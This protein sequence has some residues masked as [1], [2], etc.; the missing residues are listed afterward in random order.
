MLLLLPSTHTVLFSLQ[1]NQTNT[2][3]KSRGKRR[4]AAEERG[5]GKEVRER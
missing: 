2:S 1:Y 4:E 5:R 3:A